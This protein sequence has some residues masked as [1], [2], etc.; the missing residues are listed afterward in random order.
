MIPKKIH[1]CWFG[2][3]KLP[4]LVKKCIASWK[5]YCPDYEIIEW[6]EDNFDIKANAYVKEAYENRKYAFVTDYVR[7]YVMYTYG[8]IY[9]D[10]DVEVLR[11][12]DEFLSNRAFS[13]FESEMQIPTGIMASEKGLLLFKKLLD[14]YE[15]RHFADTD[16]NMDLTT[17]V[18]IIT[19]MLSERGFEPNGKF[20]VVEG[21]A[22]YPKD[23]FCPL[24]DATG[25]I[26]SSTNT[27]TIHWFRK[28]WIP[29]KQRLRSKITRVFHRIFGVNC[30]A[31]LK[32]KN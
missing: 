7:L 4:P 23:V 12:L 15:N 3:G 16:G 24:D 20:Q 28:S 13:G 26:H 14:Y 17:N 8:G 22:L 27:A 29:A 9:M 6:N 25:I 30:F 1:Y 32:G 2:R 11:P 5:K 19:S 18:H 21:L 31:W 10:T